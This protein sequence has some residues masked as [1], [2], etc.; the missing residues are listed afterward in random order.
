MGGRGRFG[1]DSDEDDDADWGGA[2]ERYSPPA[3]PHIEWPAT[4]PA[5]PATPPPAPAAPGA[6]P[7]PRA[8][9]PA[10]APPA[11]HPG[12]AALEEALF[13]VYPHVDC[14]RRVRRQA[15]FD[16]TVGL[17]SEPITDLEVL[18]FEVPGRF[19]LTMWVLAEH[20]D[21]EDD[22]A[23]FRRQIDL[24]DPTI[25]LDEMF[26]KEMIRLRARANPPNSA[27]VSV[28]FFADGQPLG[29]VTRTVRIV[30]L[31]SGRPKPIVD[32]DVG[33]FDLVPAEP[34]RE[35]DLTVT[36]KRHGDSDSRFTFAAMPAS[37]HVEPL[38]GEF[39]LGDDPAEWLAATMRQLDTAGRRAQRNVVL[40]VAR[41]IATK[42]PDGFADQLIDLRSALGRPPRVLVLT[43]DAFVPWELAAIEPSSSD[44]VEFF[45]AVAAIG[46][47]TL[48]QP[49]RPESP[50]SRDL[51]LADIRAVT[52][53][54]TD[55]LPHALEE[56]NYLRD[57]YDAR[58]VAATTDELLRCLNED[59]AWDLLHLAVHGTYRPGTERHGLQLAD[60]TYIS[61]AIVEGSLRRLRGVVFLNACLA[62]GAESVLGDWG[63]LPAAFVGRGAEA[64]IAAW[65]SVDDELA[66]K[67]S[68]KVYDDADDVAPAETLRWWKQQF[69]VTVP[70]SPVPISAL[71][72]QFHGHPTTKFVMTRKG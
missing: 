42:L 13:P 32:D 58:T 11:A 54:Y 62:G 72:Y 69:D 52:G 68:T 24:T 33:R 26:P 61:P 53:E 38:E 4:P 5:G 14:P 40:G 16:V 9:P 2:S 29:V 17:D 34:G 1:G 63:G 57:R 6:A 12:G 23:R 27:E 31:L 39:D 43:Q 36:V 28:I 70:E 66:K 37:D 44:R 60:G 71:A 46:R 20:F 41:R 7:P 35:V 10:G 67:V 45:G 25:P 55:P 64:V 51:R 18:P 21:I 50:S 22:R 48:H 19:E 56:V 59:A 65:W 30:T 8:T 3:A 49:G 47:W 15:W